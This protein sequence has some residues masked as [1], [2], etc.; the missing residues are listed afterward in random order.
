ME[1]NKESRN[2]PTQIGPIDILTKGQN[3][4]N[5]GIVAFSKSD[6]AI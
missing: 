4:V 1:W 5:W 2:K 6:A 3:Q